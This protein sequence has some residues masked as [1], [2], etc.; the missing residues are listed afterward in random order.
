[1]TNSQRKSLPNAATA[2]V[3]APRIADHAGLASERPLALMMNL[4]HH[5]ARCDAISVKPE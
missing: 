1:M 2:A 3:A 4:P 5:I